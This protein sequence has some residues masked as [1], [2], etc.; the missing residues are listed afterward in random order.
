[1]SA[2]SPRVKSWG[3]FSVWLSAGRIAAINGNPKRGGVDSQASQGKLGV[4]LDSI[5]ERD[6]D[7]TE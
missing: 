3:S 6:N 2:Q 4:G 7:S 5:G 1:M